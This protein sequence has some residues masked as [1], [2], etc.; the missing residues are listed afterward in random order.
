MGNI[1]Y[2]E[3]MPPAIHNAAQRDGQGRWVG[4]A[5]RPSPYQPGPRE[6]WPL[7][8]SQ[9]KFWLPG[10]GPSLWW[11]SGSQSPI[12]PPPEHS[13]TWTIG[14]AGPGTWGMGTGCL[15]SAHLPLSGP[16]DRGQRAS[17][18]DPCVRAV[19]TSCCAACPGTWCWCTAGG[20]LFL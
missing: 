17:H 3:D 6:E 7:Q 8:V 13:L 4:L 14:P 15:P 9:G 19:V 20:S 10:P 2:N 1:R 16:G 18:P 11:G 12:P 5:D